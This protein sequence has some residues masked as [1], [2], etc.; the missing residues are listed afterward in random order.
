MLKSAPRIAAL[1]L[2]VVMATLLVTSDGATGA[3]RDRHHA[4][5]IVGGI[6]APP[7]VSY[8]HHNT[9]RRTCKRCD[10]HCTPPIT[11]LMD[12]TDPTC[13]TRCL[14]IPMCIPSCCTDV[15]TCDSRVGLLG[16]GRVNYEWCCG[17]RVEVVFKR[18]GD[19]VVHSFGR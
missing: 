9:L 3:T 15:P 11:V 17:Y 16:R 13:C 12:V 6:P 10:C 7:C 5:V 18:N 8:A 19:V 1:G 14:E 2:T 4:P